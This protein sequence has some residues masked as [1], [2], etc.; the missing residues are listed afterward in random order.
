MCVCVRLYN[1]TNTI[2]IFFQ[3]S[4]RRSSVVMHYNV[5]AGSTRWFKRGYLF[6][7]SVIDFCSLTTCSL[8][9]FQ[10]F[11]NIEI[12]APRTWT[13]GTLE[14]RNRWYTN[15]THC[16]VPL[17]FAESA[18]A[19]SF[20]SFFHLHV[21]CIDLHCRVLSIR[22]ENRKEKILC[23]FRLASDQWSVWLACFGA[24]KS[25]LFYCDRNSEKD[26]ERV[27]VCVV[28]LERESCRN[29]RQ[30]KVVKCEWTHIGQIHIR[31]KWQPYN[32]AGSN[33]SIAFH[34][35]VAIICD[36]IGAT[37]GHI[38]IRKMSEVSVDA[39]VRHDQSNKMK[40]PNATFVLSVSL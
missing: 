16:A 23:R 6:F 40:R 30:T 12:Y 37:G 35:F 13:F 3:L 19:V 9:L 5:A 26:T 10:L 39:K 34:L 31:N 7:Y 38:G 18:R 4:L 1:C 17:E 15:K 29:N 20:L 21:C 36:I 22:N 32:A 14:Q 24:T 2:S 25:K 33:V 28:K 27:C 8:W 11:I